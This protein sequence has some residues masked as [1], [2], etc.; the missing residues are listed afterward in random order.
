MGPSMAKVV[1]LLEAK[2]LPYFSQYANWF[3]PYPMTIYDSWQ[4]CLSI[5]SSTT[6]RIDRD[7]ALRWSP[8]FVAFSLCWVHV[9][10]CRSVRHANNCIESSTGVLKIQVKVRWGS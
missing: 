8:I 6:Q 9:R 5:I 4:T 7:S 10:V 1:H 2:V 3:W